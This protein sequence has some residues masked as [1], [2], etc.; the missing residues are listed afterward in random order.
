MLTVYGIKNC[1]TVKKALKWLDGEG[2]A[3]RFHDLRADGV[4]AAD[5]KRW[6]DALGWESLLNRRS[7]TWR[8]LPETD[9][10]GLDEAKAL[11]LMVQHP[12]LIK[13]PVFEVNSLIL[14]GFSDKVRAQL[15]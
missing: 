5:V 4:Q 7:T 15:G 1:D 3:Y 12:T 9:K 11:G 14:N 8:E 13:R 10:E 2:V 6:C